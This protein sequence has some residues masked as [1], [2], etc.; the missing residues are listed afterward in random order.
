MQGKVASI[1]DSKIAHF[2]ATPARWDE[3]ASIHRWPYTHCIEELDPHSIN[4][5]AIVWPQPNLLEDEVLISI[6]RL[7]WR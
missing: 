7:V 5:E 6:W 3:Q 1:Q 2:V 4:L